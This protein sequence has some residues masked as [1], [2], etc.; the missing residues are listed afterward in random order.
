MELYLSPK[1]FVNTFYKDVSQFL[2]KKF[3]KIGKKNK[4]VFRQTVMNVFLQTKKSFK[5]FEDLAHITGIEEEVLIL[6]L[7]SSIEA[8]HKI[9]IDN[10]KRLSKVNEKL[11]HTM[12]ISE[13]ESRDVRYKLTKKEEVVKSKERIVVSLENKLRQI[14][15]EKDGVSNK[16]AE[17]KKLIEKG[18]WSQNKKKDQQIAES[19]KNRGNKSKSRSRKKKERSSITEIL[20]L[21]DDQEQGDKDRARDIFFYDIPKYW[22]EKNIVK[23]LSK[24]G[25]V[26]RIHIKKQFKYI[27]VK[28]K[29]TLFEQFSKSFNG[30]AFGMGINKH[31]IR[32][33][34][35]ELTVKERNE[36]DRFQLIRDMTPAEIEECK[37]DE[38]TFLKK[39]KSEELVA[40]MKVLK[41]GKVWKLL[42]Y[43]ASETNMEQFFTRALEREIEW[44]FRQFKRPFREKNERNGNKEN[45]TSKNSHK[46]VQGTS[47]GTEE[48]NKV[49][50]SPPTLNYGNN[51]VLETPPQRIFLELTGIAQYQK[52]NRKQSQSMTIQL[53]KE[54]AEVIITEQDVVNT[55]DRFRKGLLKISQEKEAQQTPSGPI[56]LRKDNVPPGEVVTI[57]NEHRKEEKLIKSYEKLSWPLD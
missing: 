18:K 57:I 12:R 52:D 29:I 48:V 26:Y 22:N 49:L 28:A 46:E 55:V 16:L 17:T 2:S 13:K 51:Y 21:T 3:H 8:A 33:Y 15:K 25:K 53:T 50:T 36:R 41:I 43:L 9:Y 47:S 14:K 38:Y 35:G 34:D 30:G 56:S 32:W 1:E 44:S 19:S 7:E 6:L 11:R 10:I 24:I 54:E 42:V 4:H 39:I 31:F 37:M 23:E 20:I 40:A 45:G 27:S 5:V